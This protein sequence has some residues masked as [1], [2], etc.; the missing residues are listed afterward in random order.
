MDVG[1]HYIICFLFRMEEQANNAFLIGGM[2]P[3][4]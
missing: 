1:L 2:N 3:Q 4:D